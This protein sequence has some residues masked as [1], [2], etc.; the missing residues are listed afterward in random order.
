[1]KPNQGYDLREKEL[2]TDITDGNRAIH[3]SEWMETDLHKSQPKLSL[4]RKRAT[5]L[6]RNG[7]LG[8]NRNSA[9]GEKIRNLR[10]TEFDTTLETKHFGAM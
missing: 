5:P 3:S 4:L 8:E 2:E 9:P 1:M 10:E 7:H 6:K